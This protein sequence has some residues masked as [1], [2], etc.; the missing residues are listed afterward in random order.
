MIQ[1]HAQSAR[2]R[3]VGSGPTSSVDVSAERFGADHT[4]TK[5]LQASNATAGG[6][7][8]PGE[9]SADFIELLRATARVEAAGPRRVP[10]D[11]G[12]ITLPKLTAGASGGWIGEGTNI[13]YSDQTLGNV[14]LTARKYATLTAI[15][16]DLL[17]YSSTDIDRMVRDDLVRD[18][19]LAVDLAFLRGTGTAAA[20]KG[21]SQIEGINTFAGTGTVNLANVTND[22]GRAL[23]EMMDDNVVMSNTQWGFAPR[24]WR[25]LFTVRDGN[26]NQV[27][28]DEMASGMLFGFPWWTTTQIPINLGAGTNESEIY[29]VDYDDI[30]VGTASEVQVSASADAAYHD[31]TAV[32]AA[33]SRDEVVVRVIVKKDINARHAESVLLITGV[34]YAA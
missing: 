3:L 6:L 34:T 20:P 23:Q 12:T 1:C 4:V 28:R 25:Y 15:S 19:A 2:A 22:L 33:F 32:V 7:T 21:M 29:L 9:L 27:F 10:L 17:D 16:N 24:T 30:V 8:I 26:G 14:T 5:A 11:A 31:G 18:A 13:T